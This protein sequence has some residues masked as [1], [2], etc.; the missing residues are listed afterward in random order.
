MSAD[1]AR[2]ALRTVAP[3]DPE[4]S[5]AVRD[6]LDRAIARATLLNAAA[7]AVSI[8]GC[9]VLAPFILRGLATERFGL[10]SLGGILLGLYQTLD[11][12]LVGSRTNIPAEFPIL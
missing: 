2:P 11:L 1:E 12:G 5:V 4:A 3:V 9:L 8:L 7:R 6:F 10:S